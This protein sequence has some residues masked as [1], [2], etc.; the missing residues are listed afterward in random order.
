M[1]GLLVR[2]LLVAL[3]LG[4][5]VTFIVGIARISKITEYEP[6]ISEA[7]MKAY[8]GRTVAELERFLQ[9]RRVRLT[10]YQSLRE[11][12]RY[13]FFWKGIARGSVG[14]CVAVFLGCIIVG[15]AERRRALAP[16]AKATG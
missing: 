15:G 11:Q 5:V 10:R 8:E 12:M 16:K 3:L 14:P 13:P 7:E 6:G 1:R 9:S 2:S 4:P